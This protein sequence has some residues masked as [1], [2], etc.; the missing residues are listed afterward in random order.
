MVESSKILTVSYGTFSCT[1]EG[2]DDSFGTMK[3]IAEYFRD[4]AADDRYF[5][6]EPPTPDVHMLAKIAER[7]ITRRVD[8]RTEDGGIVLRAS[9]AVAPA[10]P[11]QAERP[12]PVQVAAASV[13]PQVTQPPKDHTLDDFQTAL[14]D[15]TADDMEPV[16]G[17][18][19]ED[20]VSS[21]LVASGQATPSGLTFD[22]MVEDA[23]AV[24]AHPDAESVAAKLQ[25]IRAVVGK[26]PVKAE[27][28][29][30]AEDLPAQDMPDVADA[31]DDIVEPDIADIVEPAA[32]DT[33]DLHEDIVE[34]TVDDVAEIHEDI[35]EDA[36]DDVA[37]IHEELVAEDDADEFHE[38]LAE[39]ISDAEPAA[40]DLSGLDFGN[41]DAAADQAEGA[42][43]DIEDEQEDVVQEA[44]TP[45]DDEDAMLSGLAAKVAQATDAA[46]DDAPA[47]EEKPAIR[48]QILRIRKTQVEE[49][50]V[51]APAA[52]ADSF[53]FV[54]EDLAEEDYD[55][56][57]YD[58]DEDLPNV[59][60]LDGV[61]DLEG[62]DAPISTSLSDDEEADL[63]EELAEVERD[64]AESQKETP[65]A[66]QK[67]R[68]T[69]P[70]TDDATMS[71]ILDQ[72]DQQLNEPEGSRRRNAI[73]QLKAAVAATEAARQLGD[74]S[75]AKETAE[76]AFRDDLKEVVRPS[77]PTTPARPTR[78]QPT[79]ARTERPRPAPLK[80]IASQRVD[81]PAPAQ[82]AAP[83]QPRRVATAAE[84]ISAATASSFAEFAEEMGATALPDLLE[85]A[86]AYTAF[87]EGVEDFSRPQIM[88]KVQLSTETAFSREDGLRSFGTLLRQGRISKVRNGRFQVSDETRFRPETKA[89]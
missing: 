39:Q 46:E 9:Q 37:E 25:R 54:A 56:A 31:H 11:P 22:D 27:D 42:V 81:A 65:A 21:P 17:P 62:F 4:L 79:Q 38:D 35:V 75:D 68:L 3:A 36:V 15:A 49:V 10:M 76:D 63:M 34:D 50:T 85:A 14:S 30:F 13:A 33:A 7:E 24:P 53:D 84:P 44:A 58:L 86:A 47:A 45:V 72:T 8:A 61:E 60:A 26:A 41:Q 28:A 6:A 40:I 12:D 83:V 71:H 48:A 73:A 59:A 16:A 89:G 88:K 57:D 29:D 87:V 5:G 69:L 70:E 55:D 1:L 66:A 82:D 78:V 20:H 51:E 19:A 32:D 23:P 67:Q 18:E 52:D 80:L 43:A 74:K 2:F 77:R 64:F